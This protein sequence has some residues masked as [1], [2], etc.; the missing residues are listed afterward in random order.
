MSHPKRRNGTLRR[1]F[2]STLAWP[3]NGAWPGKKN[4]QIQIFRKIWWVSG[5]DFPSNP[6]IWEYHN[7]YIGKKNIYIYIPEMLAYFGMVFRPYCNWLYSASGEQGGRYQF[8][9]MDWFEN[10]RKVALEK[11]VWWDSM[12]YIYINNMTNHTWKLAATLWCHQT[13]LEHARLMIFSHSNLHVGHFPAMFD[14]R[15]V[16]DMGR[17]QPCSL[18][19]VQIKFLGQWYVSYKHHSTVSEKSMISHNILKLIFWLWINSLNKIAGIYG[20]D[21][22]VLPPL[23]CRNATNSFLGCWKVLKGLKCA[24][25]THKTKGHSYATFFL[26]QKRPIQW[27]GVSHLPFH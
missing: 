7:S 4:N 10:H 21:W 2:H 22:S 9:R 16:I 5:V 18:W 8:R 23:L 14:H 1:V 25:L 11:H 20:C 3:R 17:G 19:L 6:L 26:T 15:R 27:S 24:V 12:G 13:W